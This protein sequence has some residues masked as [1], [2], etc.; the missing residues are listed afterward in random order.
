MPPAIRESTRSAHSGML[1]AEFPRLASPVPTRWW[2]VVEN[3]RY[4][5]WAK[6]PDTATPTPML[7]SMPRRRTL[8]AAHRRDRAGPKPTSLV[9]S[10]RLPPFTGPSQYSCNSPRSFLSNSFRPKNKV[11][12]RARLPR[13]AIPPVFL[14]VPSVGSSGPVGSVRLAYRGLGVVYRSLGG[15]EPVLDKIGVLRKHSSLD[16]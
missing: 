4:A 8:S 9:D 13:L 15:S 1:L 12:C 10:L 6:T 14:R 16:C 7:R 3:A 2:N 11:G 5:V